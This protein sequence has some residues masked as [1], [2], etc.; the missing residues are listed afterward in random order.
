MK[1]F[2]DSPLTR[3]LF[4]NE[5]DR[6]PLSPSEPDWAMDALE[7]LKKGMVV[8]D[9]KGLVLRIN[10]SACEILGFA[11]PELI[12]Q[13]VM[14]VAPPEIQLIADRF[15]A[16][17]LRQSP[18]ITSHWVLCHKNGAYLTV[19]A[20]FKA[21]RCPTHGACVLIVFSRDDKTDP[22][23][24]ARR[25]Q[26]ERDASSMA[27]SY[28]MLHQVIN[29]IPARIAYFDSKTLHCIFGNEAF[30][31]GY[32]Q[33]VKALNGKP[34]QSLMLPAVWM[35]LRPHFELAAQGQ[36]A[37]F[38][39][40]ESDLAGITRC[41]QC[42]LTPHFVR[43]D[44]QIGIF[45]LSVDIT[46]H[47]QTEL[48]LRE[49]ESRLHQALEAE[50]ELGELKTAFVAMASHE[51]RTPLTA[52]Q[53]ASDLILH[54]GDKMTTPDREASLVDIQDAVQRMTAIM[55][56]ILI[57]G[58][59]GH[60]EPASLTRVNLQL[61]FEKMVQETL[62]AYPRALGIV[63]EPPQDGSAGPN[64]QDCS[65]QLDESG[66]RQVL[67][68]LLSNACKYSPADKPVTLSWGK[69]ANGGTPQLCIN[70][71]D[72]GIGIPPDHLP[73]L[74]ESFR[75]ASNV[76]SIQG[77]GLGLPIAKRAIENM[78]G[79]IEVI[80]QADRGSCFMVSLPW[81]A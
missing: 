1:P 65:V 68:N 45:A 73:H 58:R 48:A 46:D 51:L 79:S 32:N 9:A 23:E 28:G 21:R 24:M 20:D 14:L 37:K 77:T 19:T 22:I 12:G 40:A 17:L 29:S 55:E 31:Q 3:W 10:H 44:A 36:V 56:N 61:F 7:I 74:F 11:A 52:I 69:R 47:L 72:Q 15:V 27:L 70:V 62:K 18:K 66:L 43:A 5:A 59:I 30:A 6:A 67:G 60:G 35:S 25:L 71:M 26:S 8:I 57:L 4:A 33:H 76:G 64:T 13:S 49:S 38:D 50:K 34:L 78:G 41:F 75:R 53:G 81:V 54:Y 16:G 39:Y 42:E 80:S 2:R 63:I